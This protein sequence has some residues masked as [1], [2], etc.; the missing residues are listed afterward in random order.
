MSVMVRKRFW[1][2]VAISEGQGGYLVLLDGKPI[3]T[4]AKSPLL[5]PSQRLA[6]AI[7]QEWDALEQEIKPDLMPLTRCA[8]SSI[9]K[10]AIEFEA[11]V[12]ILA[13][14]AGSDLLC[15]RANGP[16]ALV[17]RQSEMWDPWLEW[18]AITHDAPL[19]AVSGVMHHAQ[20][21]QSLSNLRNAIAAHDPFELVALHDMIAL[22]GSCVL[23]L[24]VSAGALSADQAWALSRLDEDW[25]AEFWG[26]DDEA[27]AMAARKQND[28]R[29]AD[30]F[31]RLLRAD[32]R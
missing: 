25:Q 20:P 18:A 12:E 9:D 15:Y 6:E 32:T 14:Y 4:P 2:E 10:V 3:K 8:N 7:A 17:A 26:H 24:A 16:D 1:K 11:V 31:L 21:V 19:M 5:V 30:Q 28:L 22:T 23:G 13:E 27:D 29:N